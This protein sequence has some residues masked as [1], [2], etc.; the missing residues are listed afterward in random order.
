MR[1]TLGFDNCLV[2]LPA[3]RETRRRSDPTEARLVVVALRPLAD[4][5]GEE[6]RGNHVLGV[7]SGGR[8]KHLPS[9]RHHHPA[10]AS[11]RVTAWQE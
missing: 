11:L 3:A 5:D 1:R 2:Y 7:G 9:H 10:A 8:V 6:E 4:P